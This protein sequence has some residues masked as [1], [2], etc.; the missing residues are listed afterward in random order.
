MLLC[1]SMSCLQE[2]YFL[3][4]NLTRT[5]QSSVQSIMMI[6]CIIITSKFWAT[7]IRQIL[8]YC[9]ALLLGLRGSF[10]CW[11]D[12]AAWIWPEPREHE[13]IMFWLKTS[14]QQTGRG[15]K[16]NTDANCR[17]TINFMCISCT[18]LLEHAR[19]DPLTRGSQKWRAINLNWLSRVL[20]VSPVIQV[21]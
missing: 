21:N 7:L 1:V 18:C 3:K 12:V 14:A 11:G 19:L 6:I 8:S 4:I 15:D 10:V 17:V 9:C 13:D 16:D 5:V 20:H 2:D